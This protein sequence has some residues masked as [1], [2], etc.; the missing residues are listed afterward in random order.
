M[1]GK[2]GRTTWPFNAQGAICNPLLFDSPDPPKCAGKFQ[3]SSVAA[4]AATRTNRRDHRGVQC[5]HK[6]YSLLLKPASRVYV[7]SL[8]KAVANVDIL[9]SSSFMRRRRR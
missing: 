9:V 6:S 2:K 7:E 3:H 4:A 1:R 5:V 8:V